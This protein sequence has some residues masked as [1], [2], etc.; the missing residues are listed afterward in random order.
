MVEAFYFLGCVIALNFTHH[1][2]STQNRSHRFQA[3]FIKFI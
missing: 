3:K 2:L 1:D